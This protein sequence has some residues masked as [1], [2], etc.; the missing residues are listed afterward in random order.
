MTELT[1]VTPRNT[2]WTT[3]YSVLNTN[4]TDPESRSTPK[5]VFASFPDTEN[6]WDGYPVVIIENPSTGF[7]RMAHGAGTSVQ[8]EK[9]ASSVITVYAAKNAQIDSLLDDVSNTLWGNES[10]FT[11]LGLHNMRILPSEYLSADKTSGDKVHA[12]ALTV[13]WD[14]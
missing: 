14:A 4:L 12:G 10:T 7:E 13:E 8:R 9:S 5:W 1:G 2:I 11:A 3:L 6:S